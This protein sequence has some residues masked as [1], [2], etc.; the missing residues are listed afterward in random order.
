VGAP[1]LAAAWWSCAPPVA[2]GVERRWP[3]GWRGAPEASIA[4]RSARPLISSVA[5]FPSSRSS[6]SCIELEREV[7]AHFLAHCDGLPGRCSPLPLS[8]LSSFPTPRSRSGECSSHAPLLGCPAALLVLTRK[9]WLLLGWP[10]L[11]RLTQAPRRPSHCL[12]HRVV[13][14]DCGLNM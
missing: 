8:F 13:S 7:A 10:T 14:L 12:K 1:A 5:V 9:M 4:N 3:R 6:W 2:Q 11:Q